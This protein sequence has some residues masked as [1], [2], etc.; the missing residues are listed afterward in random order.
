MKGHATYD[1]QPMTDERRAELLQI[2]VNMRKAS[3]VFYWMAFRCGN[4]AFI[5][6][7]GLMNEYINVC[8]SAAK[9][10]IDFT[11]ASTHTGV[12]LPFRPHHQQYLLEKL[13]CIY[14]PS[15]PELF[16]D[17]PCASTP[18]TATSP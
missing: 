11:M 7:T 2:T 8:D 3:D 17:P 9:Q 1:G 16:K 14:G 12:A 13:E 15:M 10:G 4:H 5:E 18:S 6:F